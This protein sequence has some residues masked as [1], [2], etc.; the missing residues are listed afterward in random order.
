MATTKGF[1]TAF[2]DMCGVSE[3]SSQSHS[4][5]CQPDFRGR[6]SRGVSVSFGMSLITRMLV[7]YYAAPALW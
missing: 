3:Q 4:V 6:C 7:V 1:A 5:D 2:R